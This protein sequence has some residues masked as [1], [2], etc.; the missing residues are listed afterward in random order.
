VSDFSAIYLKKTAKP[1]NLLIFL[2]G[3]NNTHSE[4]EPAYRYL[5]EHCPDLAILAPEGK[6]CSSQDFK[7]KSWYKIPGFDKERKR[8]DQNTPIEEIVRIYNQAG[9]ELS[10]TATELNRFIDQNQ[11]LY[12]F[13]DQNT[14][15][16]GFSQGAMVAIWTALCREHKLA[17]CFSLAG[18]AAANETLGSLLRAKPP[19]YLLHGDKDF[20]VQLKC[21]EYTKNWLS[22]RQIQ[23]ES[24]IFYGL[25]HRI[26]NSELDYIAAAISKPKDVL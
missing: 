15:I 22:E 23:V 9:N 8:T 16:A 21:L 19:V 5:L 6:F 2:H 11:K 1:A 3:Y 17:G 10:K 7:Q 14:Y 13:T 24:K 4:M 18:L 25:D 12:G 26:E 20:Q